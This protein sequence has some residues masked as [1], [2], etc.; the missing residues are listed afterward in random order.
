MMNKIIILLVISLMCL[1]SLALA[2]TTDPLNSHISVS[3]DIPQ[4]LTVQRPDAVNQ[5]S[6]APHNGESQAMEN[7]I[8]AVSPNQSVYYDSDHNP[9]LLFDSSI[10]SVNDIPPTPAPENPAVVPYNDNCA[11]ITPELLTGDSTLVFT[12]NNA[13]ATPDCPYLGPPEVWVAVTT[14]ECMDLVLNYC[15]STPIFRVVFGVISS[16]C[17]CG[18][19]IPNSGFTF[20]DCGDFNGTVRYSALPAG[21]YYIPIASFGPSVGDYI[22]HVDGYVCPPPATNDNCSDA[23]AIGDV[24]NLRFTTSYATFDGPGGCITSPNIWYVYTAPTTGNAY[25]SLL[26]STYNTMVAVYDGASC[27]PVGPTLSCNDDFGLA[28]SCAIV[29]V[30]AGQQYLIE[31]GGNGSSVGNGW[32]TASTDP[33]PLNDDCEDVTP[34]PFTPGTPLTLTGTTV[35][36]SNDCSNF[37]FYPEVW[38]AVTIPVCMDLIID[39]CGT[40][41]VF[42]NV[43]G[44]IANSCPCGSAIYSSGMAQSCPD[45]NWRIQFIALPAGTYYI[46]ILSDK[47]HGFYGPYTITVDGTPCP[48]APPNDNCVDVTAEPLFAGSPLTFTGDNTGATS[49]C[50]LLPQPEVWHSFEIFECMNVTVNYC[51]TNPIFNSYYIVLTDQCPCDNYITGYQYEYYSCENGALTLRFANLQPGVYYLPIYTDLGSM[52]PYSIQVSGEPCLPVP[53]NDDCVNAIELAIPSSTTGYTLSA[54]WDDAPICYS[55]IMA[56]GVWYKVT[57]NGNALTVS[58]CATS[59][60]FDTRVNIYSGN[61]GQFECVAGTDNGCTLPPPANYASVVQFCSEPGTVYYILVQGTNN[62]M[63]TFQIDISDGEPCTPPPPTPVCSNNSLYGQS[64]TGPGGMWN[65]LN[66]D[67]NSQPNP[68]LITDN[69]SN[70]A[71]DICQIKFWGIEIYFNISYSNCVEDPAHFQIKF[72]DDNGGTPGPEVGTYDVTVT[73]VPTGLYYDIFELK[74][75]TVDINPCMTLPNGWVSIQG[76]GVG[77][78]PGDCLFYWANALSGDGQCFQS[79]AQLSED[80][81]FCLLPGGGCEYTVGDVN[82]NG[83]FNGI[84]VTYGVGYFKGGNVPPYACDCNGSVWYVAGDVNGNCTFNGIDITYMV[85]YFKGGPAPIPC[86]QCAPSSIAGKHSG[87]VRDMVK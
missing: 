15:G 41:P 37:G 53:A 85:S 17:P 59:T 77:G 61:C 43:F 4:G 38:E 80:A 68:Y 10:K 76:V 63:G 74:E 84:D 40:T 47:Q 49:D 39:Y 50:E 11:D 7:S 58:T 66:S 32:L 3:K 25:I 44:V 34:V 72:Y 19:L 6:A 13:G 28:Q 9:I 86:P 82:N 26:G 12:G 55:L 36:A 60:N 52:G 70:I 46:P 73:G 35:G 20:Y 16:S 64:P 71:D 31:V 87:H 48:V 67:G 14:T 2:I 62:D 69:F 23:I 29:P 27:D 56:A 54:N 83:A 18:T 8:T 78:D 21:T 79:G 42:G 65:F 51:G 75:Y 5:A 1:T 33:K 24:T 30:V 81:A 45:G 22:L 57:G